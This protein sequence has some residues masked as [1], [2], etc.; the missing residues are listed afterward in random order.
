MV[1]DSQYMLN[2]IGNYILIQ[3]NELYRQLVFR[4]LPNYVQIF[5]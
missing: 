5:I 1:H 4:L 2:Y 3:I